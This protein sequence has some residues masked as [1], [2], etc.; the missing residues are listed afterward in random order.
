VSGLEFVRPFSWVGATR[1]KFVLYP[2]II[3]ILLLLPAAKLPGAR[4]RFFLAVLTALALLKFAVLPALL[5]AFNHKLLLSLKTRI[6]RDG[7]CLQN[8][9]YT[10]GPAAAVT[11]L[12]RLHLR[13]EEGEIAVWARTTSV[14]G[15]PPDVLAKT[16]REHYG[17]LGLTATWRDFKNIPELKQSGL[18]LAIVKHDVLED[19]YVTILKVTDTEVEVGDPLDGL[20]SY[21]Y[22]DFAK[23]WRYSGVVLAR[24]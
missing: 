21:S 12:R 5:P 22:A 20:V 11:A 1:A 8:T 17:I 18:V 2:L 7:I 16:L 24:P 6:D 10:C 15:T 4:A 9:G 13:A 23:L 14:A 19:H 3:P